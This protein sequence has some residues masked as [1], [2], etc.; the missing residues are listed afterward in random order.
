MAAGIRITPASLIPSPRRGEG[1]GEGFEH[2]CS[3]GIGIGLNSMLSAI[4]FNNRMRVGAKEIDHI[5]IDW[6]LSSEFPTL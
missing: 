4:K 3:R 6:E 2:F 1:Q 5:A